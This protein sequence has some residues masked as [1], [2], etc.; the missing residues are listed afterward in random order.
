MSAKFTHI[1]WQQTDITAS[2]KLVLLKLADISGNDGN[3]AFALSDVAKECLL[4]EFGL[5][6]VLTALANKG[7]L[8]KGQVESTPQGQR[9]HFT[10]ASSEPNRLPVIEASSAAPVVRQPS[11]V[12]TMQESS[13]PGWAV[14]SFDLYKVPPNS[15]DSVWQ[16]FVREHGTN[17]TNITRLARQ[18][19]D[20]LEY[21]KRSGSLQAVIGEQH[22][23]YRKDKN[24][25]FSSSKKESQ[26]ATNSQYLS[27]HDL[28]EFEIPDWA[29]QTI[30]FS[31]LEIDPNLFWEKFVVYYKTRA[32]E[33]TN[34]T[35]M[36]NKLRLWIVNEKQAED[37]RK[38]AEERRRQSYQTSNKSGDVSPSEEFREY[39][40]GQGKNPNF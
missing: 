6:D 12:T 31:R 23:N 40:R 39:L 2:E 25:G 33:Y 35:Q 20:W 9:H 38:Q 22:P 15:R 30:A 32:N 3:V 4:G 24:S 16:N 7:L 14:P 18:L 28:N 1:A 5:A 29:S 11:R 26:P 34:V 17:T 36:L 10:L 27:T 37:R 13:A 21:S 8:T 19:E